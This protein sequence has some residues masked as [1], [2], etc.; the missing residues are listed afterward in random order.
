MASCK[1]TAL[2]RTSD[3]FPLLKHPV[4]SWN[5]GASCA[6]EPGGQT[7]K[8]QAVVT[9]LVL[10]QLA[11]VCYGERRES[12]WDTLQQVDGNEH[13]RYKTVKRSWEGRILWCYPP[14]HPQQVPSQEKKKDCAGQR[15]TP[16]HH[17]F[18]AVQYKAGLLH[19]AFR[20][21][22]ASPGLTGGKAGTHQG[23]ITPGISTCRI[24]HLQQKLLC[25][26]D[27]A[28]MSVWDKSY[29]LDENYQEGVRYSVFPQSENLLEIFLLENKFRCWQLWKLYLYN[30]SIRGYILEKQPC[31]K[32]WRIAERP[33]KQTD[34]CDISLLD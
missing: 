17:L 8:C 33:S 19:P 28:G 3:D 21:K 12:A 2:V 16:K 34:H 11:R 29:I 18:R 24:F 30:V 6:E 7:W 10:Q 4:T 9:P 20:R 26:P 14:N 31:E 27:Q 1:F 32:L 5:K 13:L 23:R 22:R 15:Q 25:W